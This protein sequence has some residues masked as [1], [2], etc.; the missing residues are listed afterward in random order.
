MAGRAT[1][2]TRAAQQA[3]VDHRLHEYTHDPSADSYA[4]AVRALAH[5]RTLLAR[6]GVTEARHLDIWTAMVTGLVDQQ[7]SN[8]PGGQRWT[9]LVEESIAMFL[10]HC[11][12]K[13]P[14]Q[15]LSRLS[16]TKGSRS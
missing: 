8:D 12:A 13:T 15:P 16:R 11:Q 2:A 9:G 1:P 3:R 10:A 7:V 14:A 4:P 6:N 5:A